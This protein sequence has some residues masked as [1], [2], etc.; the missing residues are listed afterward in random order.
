[1]VATPVLFITEWVDPQ[2]FSVF[3]KKFSLYVYNI[4][5]PK[6]EEN[7]NFGGR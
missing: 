1:M 4:N 2:N 7:Q 6:T 5:R 3:N